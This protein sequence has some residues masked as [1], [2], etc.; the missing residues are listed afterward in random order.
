MGN[1]NTPLYRRDYKGE[2]LTYVNDG[3]MKSI[4][5]NPRDLP[6]DMQ[7]K[8]SIVLGNGRGRLEPDVQLIINQ[9]NK[10]FVEGYK[11]VYACNAA[12]RD[13]KADYYIIKNSIFFAYIPQEKYNQIFVPNNSYYVYPETNLL[14]YIYHFDSGASAAYLAAFDGAEKVFLFGFDSN[15]GIAYNNVYANTYG[16]I[17]DINLNSYDYSYLFNVVQV[18]SNVQFYRVRNHYSVDLNPSLKNL[19]NYHEISVRDAVLIGDF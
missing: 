3:V 19:S 9:N 10:R 4:F 11:F 14:P 16:Y 17:D 5:V 12:Y 13:V 18:Y 15:D 6:H 2:S 8:S 1:L 7:V